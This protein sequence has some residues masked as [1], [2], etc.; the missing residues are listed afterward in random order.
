MEYEII[1]KNKYGVLVREKSMSN[2]GKCKY[3]G[4]NVFSCLQR[5]ESDMYGYYLTDCEAAK[6]ETEEDSQKDLKEL[7]ISTTE[8]AWEHNDLL[9]N[10]QARLFNELQETKTDS[11]KELIDLQIENKK[12]KERIGS[13]NEYLDN[14]ISDSDFVIKNR[15]RDNLEYENIMEYKQCYQNVKE[16]IKNQK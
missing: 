14:R 11:Q 1:E 13:I 12:L 8:D 7:I 3:S 4:D 9:P 5:C 10:I 16:F 2:C 15:K 6:L